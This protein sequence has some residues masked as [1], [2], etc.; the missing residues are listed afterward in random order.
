VRTTETGSEALSAD[1]A[2]H[3]P[4]LRRSF[5]NT[6]ARAGTITGMLPSRASLGAP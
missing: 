4:A 5:T 2:S 1:N 6:G 3:M